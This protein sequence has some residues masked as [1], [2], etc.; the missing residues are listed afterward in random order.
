VSEAI[1]L[2]DPEG[3]GLELYSDR[4]PGSWPRDKSS[5]SMYTRPLDLR[6]LLSLSQ[7]NRE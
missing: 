2:A 6:A 1:Y 3:N 5:L 4:P 7:A